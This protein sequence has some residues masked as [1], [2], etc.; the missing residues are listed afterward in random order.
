[1]IN[2]EREDRIKYHDDHLNPIR[3]QIKSIQDGLVKEKKDRIANE[4]KILKEIADESTNMQNDIKKE[5]IMRQEKMQD[6]DDF[7]T[8]DTELTTKF[9]EKFEKNAIEEADKFMDDLEQEMNS[10]FEHQNNILDNMSKF[11]GKFQETLK[12]FG[13]DV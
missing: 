5:S 8:Q 7:L 13:K 12:I 1:M 4:K 9:L 11:V 10:R 3:A 2:K 6:L